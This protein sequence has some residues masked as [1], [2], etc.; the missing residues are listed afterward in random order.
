L[1]PRVRVRVRVRAWTQ[2]QGRGEDQRDELAHRRRMRALRCPGHGARAARR[3]LCSGL[4]SGCAVLAATVSGGT[5]GTAMRGGARRT[6]RCVRPVP[7]LRVARH[8]LACRSPARPWCGGGCRGVACCTMHGA[9]RPVA[10]VGLK[11][12]LCAP[13]LHLPLASSHSRT[14]LSSLPP[15]LP[16][17][18]PF[19]PSL[20]P[21]LPR[22]FPSLARSLAPA[23]SLPGLRVLS[24]HGQWRCIACRMRLVLTTGARGC[25]GGIGSG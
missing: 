21:S 25:I 23:R 11:P 2:P 24:E 4:G 7:R 16:S 5:H 19:P 13:S 9:K 3:V 12:P 14:L 1:L 10:R 8:T 22:S 15:T 18:Y 6:L 17:L 20:P